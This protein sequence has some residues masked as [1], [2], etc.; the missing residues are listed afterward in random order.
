MAEESGGSAQSPSHNL[1]SQEERYGEAGAPPVAGSLPTSPN[2]GLAGPASALVVRGGRRWGGQAADLAGLQRRMLPAGG[3][4]GPLGGIVAIERDRRWPFAAGMPVRLGA[5]EG[6]QECSLGDADGWQESN[7]AEI[8]GTPA[9]RVAS[10][11]TVLCACPMREV[12]FKPV[13]IAALPPVIGRLRL[14]SRAH[15]SGHAPSCPRSREP[16]GRISNRS[17]GDSRLTSWRQGG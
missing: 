13:A 1:S 11:L 10:R 3:T 8:A 12:R 2:F 4:R 16:A 7:R 9:R 6:W 15:P 14:H 17:P 5:L